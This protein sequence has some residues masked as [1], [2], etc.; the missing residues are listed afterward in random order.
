MCLTLSM[1][2]FFFADIGTKF[3]NCYVL[4]FQNIFQKFDTKLATE[5]DS[6]TFHFGKHSFQFSV[7]N[8]NCKLYNLIINSTPLQ[9]LLLGAVKILCQV[10]RYK[11]PA[12]ERAFFAYSTNPYYCPKRSRIDTFIWLLLME[13]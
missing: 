9:P 5:I 6:N 2:H 11:T 1:L 8:W 13:S 10:T 12:R 7:R 4:Y 3:P